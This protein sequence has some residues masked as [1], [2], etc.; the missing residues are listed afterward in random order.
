[1]LAKVGFDR[2]SSGG[3]LTHGGSLANLT[4]FLAVPSTERGKGRFRSS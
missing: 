4:E 1:M 3:V 2:D